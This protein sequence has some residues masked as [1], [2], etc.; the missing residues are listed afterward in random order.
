VPRGL[1]EQLHR[2]SKTPAH[3]PLSAA[4]SLSLSLSLSLSPSSPSSRR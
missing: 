3:L 1:V 4:S 2:D